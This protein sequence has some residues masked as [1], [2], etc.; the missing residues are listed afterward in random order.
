M[1]PAWNFEMNI[2]VKSDLVADLTPALSVSLDLNK[3]TSL[4]LTF[5]I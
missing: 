3:V 2:K 4:G 5:S 1:K